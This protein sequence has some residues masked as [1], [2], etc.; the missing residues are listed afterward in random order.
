MSASAPHDKP[1]GIFE[2]EPNKWLSRTLER[3][4]YVLLPLI[5]VWIAEARF[6]E[7]NVA[8]IHN[9]GIIDSLK[10]AAEGRR[11]LNE[12]N[13][14]ESV[15]RAATFERDS[16]LAP[17]LERRRY[18]VDSLRALARE[19]TIRA[20][21]IQAS[22][23]SLEA[24]LAAAQRETE[25]FADSLR[26]LQAMKSDLD[27]ELIA[28]ADTLARIRARVSETYAKV[29]ALK[30]DGKKGSGDKSGGSDGK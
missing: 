6:I 1:R 28:K 26:T 23:D 8:E 16:L 29:A 2:R 4:W 7:P 5:G 24:V 21:E 19:D 14:S 25:V 17:A 27:T 3:T 13:A 11:L 15:I 30:E 22:T 10:A 18:M 20:A 12:M 9:A